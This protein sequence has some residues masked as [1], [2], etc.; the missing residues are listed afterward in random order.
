[1]TA[2]EQWY[3]SSEK[4]SL[5]LG[6]M[7]DYRGLS[8]YIPIEDS[9]RFPVGET[10]VSY[11][12]TTSDD[13]VVEVPDEELSVALYVPGMYPSLL[14]DLVARVTIIDNNDGEGPNGTPQTWGTEGAAD[15]YT[16]YLD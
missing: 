7:F 4:S 2:R 12:L 1:A 13:N 3:G 16:S 9:M 8:D 14:G 6:G 11:D 10:T 15:S 5:W